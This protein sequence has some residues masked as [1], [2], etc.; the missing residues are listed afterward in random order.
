MHKSA[1]VLS[2]FYI[3]L[4]TGLSYLLAIVHLVVAAQN[5]SGLVPP[6]FFHGVFLLQVFRAQTSHFIVYV[7]LEVG[8]FV[9][10][11]FLVHFAF[12]HR[13]AQIASTPLAEQLR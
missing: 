1:I 2:N 7:D 12:K 4:A 5:V 13:S 11:A 9:M 8:L 10:L 3:I 6:I